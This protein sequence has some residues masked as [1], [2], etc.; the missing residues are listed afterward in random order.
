MKQVINKL[1]KFEKKDEKRFYRICRENNLSTAKVFKE[2]DIDP[3]SL[4]LIVAGERL[5]T[6]EEYNKIMDFEEK[7]LK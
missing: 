2:I 6:L 4:F 7:Y 5:C 3:S 1:Y